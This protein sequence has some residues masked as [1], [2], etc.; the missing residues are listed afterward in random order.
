MRQA[1]AHSGSARAGCRVHVQKENRTGKTGAGIRLPTNSHQKKGE[2]VKQSI[3]ILLG[4]IIT[5]CGSTLVQKREVRERA[6]SV[7]VHG[8]SIDTTGKATQVE[9]EEVEPCPPE[10]VE[11]YNAYLA[12]QGQPVPE[13]V[14][15]KL[16]AKVTAEAKVYFEATQNGVTVEGWT[17]SRDSSYSM[18]ITQNDWYLKYVAKDSIN[19]IPYEV[20]V[21]PW[22]S[23]LSLIVAALIV[24]FA[25]I[26]VIKGSGPISKGIL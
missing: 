7:L 14:R 5:G 26:I 4:I 10:V 22:W 18:S 24:I 11:G 2:E 25:I 23:W 19:R 13:P 3:I 8:I 6:D 17:N 21:T 15:K 1:I 16:A 12:Q 20:K 9:R